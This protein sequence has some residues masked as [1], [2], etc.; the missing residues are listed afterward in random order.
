MCVVLQ[1]DC[2]EKCVWFC[3]ET[4]LKNNRAVTYISLSLWLVKEH[5]L[6]LL[7]YV[8]LPITHMSV[9]G[10]CRLVSGMWCSE[11]LIGTLHHNL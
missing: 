9:V 10:R 8:Y 5:R 4:L 11:R 3:R 6:Y 2:V 7:I 1:G